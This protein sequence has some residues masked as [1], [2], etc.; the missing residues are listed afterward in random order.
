MIDGTPCAV[1]VNAWPSA[2]LA[3]SA[4]TFLLV[5]TWLHMS[6]QTPVMSSRP[7]KKWYDHFSAVLGSPG[8]APRPATQGCHGVSAVMQ[9][10]EFA[11]HWAATGTVV[12]G[13]A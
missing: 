9:G 2:S 8:L 11:S 13:V 6:I 5:D 4:A 1:S 7:Q 10:V 3:K 12:S